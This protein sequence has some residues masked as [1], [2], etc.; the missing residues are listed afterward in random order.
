MVVGGND[1]CFVCCV[2]QRRNRYC[3][4]GD[5]VNHTH[6]DHVNQEHVKS[7]RAYTAKCGGGGSDGRREAR[8]GG[9]ERLR[10]S[11]RGEG[12]SGAAAC[13]CAK[14]CIGLV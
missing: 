5:T 12:C 9:F 4:G 3:A 8:F 2:W 11:L 6:G 14:T 7:L 1:F 10:P 13:H